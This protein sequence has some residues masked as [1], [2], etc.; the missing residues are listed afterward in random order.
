AVDWSA[1]MAKKDDLVQYLRMGTEALLRSNGVEWVHASAT[2][3]GPHRIRA[4]GREYQ[5]R[6][7]VLATGSRWAPPAIE[8][9]EPEEILTSDHI[10]EMTEMP[11]RA[12]VLGSGPVEL[13]M[14]QY[15]LFMGC[16]VTLLEEGG[17]ILQEEDR[18]VA[19]RLA[20]ALKEQ[21]MEV[22]T[23]VRVM[24]VR[25]SEDGLE[26]HLESPGG[27]IQRKVDRIFHAR[28]APQLYGLDLRGLKVTEPNRGIPVDEQLQTPMEGVF[29]VGDAT[30][31]AMYSHRA[32]AMGLRA[33]ENALGGNRTLDESKIP[34]V[35]FT[36]PEVASVGLNE[37]QA[38]QKGYRLRVATIP[39]SINAKAMM[40]LETDGAVKVVADEQYGELLGVHI[41][42][43]Y[44]TELISEAVLA[45]ELEATV[46]EL[47]EAIRLHPTLSESQVEA[48]REALGRGIYVFR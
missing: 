46:E 35:Y 19:R 5:V 43:P 18:E 6:R 47:A 7:V 33:A 4:Q 48:A 14:A 29:A 17:R 26:V 16:R 22:L 40:Q 36:W 23:R 3:D 30:G 8:G 32:S 21:G 2:L 15:L 20:G 11:T 9:I 28:R 1:L 42:G 37:R 24:E 39:Y 45:M 13:E 38:K 44:A 41:V 12:A 25:K 27:S 10:L 31:G 34:R